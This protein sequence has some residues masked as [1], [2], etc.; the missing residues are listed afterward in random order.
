MTQF[1]TVLCVF[2]SFNQKYYIDR[3]VYEYL[4]S[5]V[6]A[7]VDRDNYYE[8]IF[9]SFIQGINATYY[10]K[11]IPPNSWQ[12]D[13][14]LTDTW[15]PVWAGGDFDRDG[16]F[17]ILVRGWEP[18][19]YPIIGLIGVLE[20]PDSFSYPTQEVW[21]D[22]LPGCDDNPNSVFDIDQD[23]LPEIF[24]NLND[25]LPYSFSIR[26]SDGNNHYATVYETNP[27]TFPGDHPYST[28]ACGD[29]DGDGNNEF[30]MSG[31]SGFYWV[32]EYDPDSGY[33][34]VL[35]GYIP[36]GNE[37]DCITIPSGFNDRPY[38]MI[39]GTNFSTGRIQAFIF[40]AI[41]DNTYQVVKM[42]EFPYIYGY[43]RYGFSSAGDLDGDSVP[44]IALEALPWV[45]IIKQAGN[46]SFYIWDRVAGAVTGSSTRILDVDHNGLNDLVVSGNNETRI[47]EYSPGGVDEKN[48]ALPAPTKMHLSAQPNPFSKSVRISVE[49]SIIGPIR[50]VVYDLTGRL[51]KV[52]KTT[53]R[54]V[55]WLGDDEFGKK[56]T[57]GIYFI[58][59]KSTVAG[60]SGLLKVLKVE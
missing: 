23:G 55:T 30:V 53:D 24:D 28:H 3:G 22:S 15:G 34:Q 38:F 56:V 60:V 37:R 13:S 41:A 9:R 32:Y 8:F 46:D 17:D 40:K 49:S 45:Y 43:C 51:I 21:K 20:S 42:F 35:C 16:L 36:T 18:N 5:I 48:T 19:H 39:K 27:D 50:F 33:R 1:L 14:L 58:C 11:L 4:H 29:F 59:V 44:E 12:I 7:D 10:C 25:G 52:L 47:Y 6:V 57:P 31:L 26:K 54:N 2:S